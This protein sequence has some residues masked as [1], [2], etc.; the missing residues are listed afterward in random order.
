MLIRLRGAIIEAKADRIAAK[1]GCQI[2][3]V[4]DGH[5]KGTRALDPLAVHRHIEGL[6]NNCLAALKTA[7]CIYGV[8][9][10]PRQLVT[11]WGMYDPS[12]GELISRHKTEDAARRAAARR[13]GSP[14]RDTMRQRHDTTHYLPAAVAQ[15]FWGAVWRPYRE[16]DAWH[17]GN[18]WQKATPSDD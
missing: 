13:A 1:H 10:A 2:V 3:A 5:P 7:G 6:V 14:K 9:A 4:G 11:C 18:N 15:G 12:T 16:N 8:E 17:P